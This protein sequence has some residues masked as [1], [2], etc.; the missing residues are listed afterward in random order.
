VIIDDNV[1]NKLQR[2][3]A[4]NIADE[5]KENMKSSL[6]DIV[7]FVENLNSIDISDVEATFSTIEGGTPLRDDI[8]SSSDV[9][10]TVLNNSPKSEETF[11]IVPKIIE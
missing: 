10:E 4:L 7:N 11:F 3:S 6:T 1:L 9:V 5:N 8:P 2:L